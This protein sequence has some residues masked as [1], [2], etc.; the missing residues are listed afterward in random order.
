M[1]NEL[2]L[3]KALSNQTRLRIMVLLSE[4]ELCVCQ[5]EWALGLTQVKVSRHLTVL[6]NAELVQDRREGLW[7]F[8]SLT[9]PGNELEETIHNYLKDYFPKKYDS[10]KKDIAKMKECESKP[11]EEF[12][13]IRR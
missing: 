10:F 12:C 6:K 1:K 2:K 7:I 4:K 5:L 13:T 3:F 11:L 8:Y 9:E